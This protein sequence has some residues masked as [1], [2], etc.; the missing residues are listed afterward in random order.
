MVQKILFYDIF[1]CLKGFKRCNEEGFMKT[2]NFH[3]Y[4]SKFCLM[5]YESSRNHLL[6]PKMPNKHNTESQL[7]IRV[8]QTSDL[9]CAPLKFNISK[10]TLSLKHLNMTEKHCNCSKPDAGHWWVVS[11]VESEVSE[12]LKVWQNLPTQEMPQ[13]HQ[14]SLAL[15]LMDG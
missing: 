14:H 12:K 5:T 7:D 15:V 6:N 8:L 9:T 13:L 10:W 4:L 1:E 2:A 11:A 3:V